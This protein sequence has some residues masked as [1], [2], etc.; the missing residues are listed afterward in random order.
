MITIKIDTKKQFI[1]LRNNVNFSVTLSAL[2]A[3]IYSIYIGNDI[4][5]LTPKN[6]DDFANKNL[7]YGKTIGP[8]CARALNGK[9]LINNKEYF[10]K[11]N[12]G[13]ICLHSG[14]DGYSNQL[15]KYQIENQKNYAKVQFSLQIPDM[16]IGF[17]GNSTLN[18]TYIIKDNSYDLEVLTS[19][20]C[21]K[22]TLLSLTNHT[23]FNLNE[24][25]IENLTL[26]INATEHVPFDK[27][28]LLPLQKNEKVD[29]ITSFKNEKNIFKDLK[30]DSI[31]LDSRKGY[32]H[33]YVLDEI[34]FSKPSVVLTG[35]KYKMEI[36]TDYSGIQIYTCNYDDNIEYLNNVSGLYR[37]I[38]IEPQ[39]PV[40]NISI[41][42]ANK[43]L[44]N[45]SIYR[46]STLKK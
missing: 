4:M 1:E 17:P 46:F 34:S 37:G 43:K 15:F 24:K 32:D 14:P 8:M 20:I 25:H 40:N 3:S 23:Y 21:D 9:Y 26:F 28:T 29:D 18:V 39:E 12:R 10:L 36:F 7:Y 31:F 45:R 33:N 44:E 13:D 19:F 42:R 2:G 22:D 30:D 41:L 11:T 27:K 5:T 6:Y 38:A 16:L 35:S